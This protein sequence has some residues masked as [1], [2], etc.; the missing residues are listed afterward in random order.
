MRQRWPFL[1]IAAS[2]ASVAIAHAGI[3]E[4]TQ[5]PCPARGAKVLA[6]SNRGVVYEGSNAENELEVFGCARGSTRRY[7][8]GTAERFSSSGGG[9]V[10]RE[11]V[12]GVFA[13]YERFSAEP[14][15]TPYHG[16]SVAELIVR[17]LKTG[18]IVHKVPTAPATIANTI[19]R[20]PVYE[21]ALGASGAIG[22]IVTGLRPGEREVRAVDRTGE[23]VLASGSGI[24][25]HSLQLHG[26]RLSWSQDGKR[27]SFRLL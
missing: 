5:V 12:A 20:G 21:L 4:T 15:E 25:P 2:V 27:S 26:S 16:G 9:G 23:H 7:A 3:A 10:A 6:S 19:G 17:N 13:A 18:R 22:W 14:S 1:E 24:A 11:R 8:F